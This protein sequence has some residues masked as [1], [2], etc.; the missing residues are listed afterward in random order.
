MT[1]PS[2]HDTRETE[3]RTR[4][5]LNQAILGAL[6]LICLLA[7]MACCFAAIAFFPLL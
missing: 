6:L 4:E 3:I 7:V 5:N 2:D 1:T